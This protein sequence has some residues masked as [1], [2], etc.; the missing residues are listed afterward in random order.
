MPPFVRPISRPI[1]GAYAAALQPRPPSLYPLFHPQGWSRAIGFQI[2][3]QA[4]SNAWRSPAHINH[5]R[6]FIG[7]LG[8]QARH[9]T[10]E[11]P[12]SGSIAYRL[13]ALSVNESGA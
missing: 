13:L 4:H 1:P 5:D 11:H 6:L 2:L 7:D 3:A 9:D 10:D 8:R 12:P